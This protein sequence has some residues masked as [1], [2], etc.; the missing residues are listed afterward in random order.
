MKP[1]AGNPRYIL[2]KVIKEANDM[3][4]EFD[5]GP[6]CEFLPFQT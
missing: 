6:E 2:E 4:Y 1:F 5:V 3:G